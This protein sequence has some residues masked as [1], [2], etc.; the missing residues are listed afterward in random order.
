MKLKKML[1]LLDLSFC[2]IKGV[3]PSEICELK[4][5]AILRLA[6]NSFSGGL[7]IDFGNLDELIELDIRGNH[8]GEVQG[9]SEAPVMGVLSR[10]RSLEVLRAD[11]NMIRWT[12][13]WKDRIESRGKDIFPSY[14]NTEVTATNYL[15]NL[16]AFKSAP[17]E[18]LPKNDI[19]DEIDSEGQVGPARSLEFSK[20]RKLSLSLQGPGG[21]PKSAVLR[22]SNLTSSLI[23]LNISY[24]GLI[25]LPFRIFERLK[26]LEVLNVSGNRLKRLPPFTFPKVNSRSSPNNPSGLF[27]VTRTSGRVG[28]LQLKEL[29]ASNNELEGLPKEIGDL[30]QLA[31][32]EVNGNRIQEIPPEIWKCGAL[33][34]IN[35]CSNLL[36]IFPMPE[37][38]KETPFASKLRVPKPRTDQRTD[39]MP[40][41]PLST[42]FSPPSTSPLSA[43]TDSSAKT[44][45]GKRAE[46]SLLPLGNSLESL[47][48]AGNNLNDDIYLALHRLPHLTHVNLSLNGIVDITPLLSTLPQVNSNQNTWYNH[49][50][51]LFL[52]SNAIANIPG[53]IEKARSLRWLFLNGNR[54]NTVP[55][56]LAKLNKLKVLDLSGQLGGRGD[57]SGLRYNITNWPYDWN[58]NWNIEL[59]YLNLSGNTRL[60]IKPSPKSSNSSSDGGIPQK[61]LADFSALTKLRMLGLMD[62]TCLVVPPDETIDRRIRTTGSDM[63]M[64]G[65][66]SGH[67]GYGVAD[68]LGIAVDTPRELDPLTT[69]LNARA[70]SETS[71]TSPLSITS[72]ITLNSQ[73]SQTM[74]QDVNIGVWDLVQP[75]FRGRDNEALFGVFDGRGSRYGNRFAKYLYDNLGIFFAKELNVIESELA[76]STS[77][78]HIMDA[79]ATPILDSNLIKDALRRAF[80][81]ANRE[82]GNYFQSLVDNHHED[83]EVSVG[84]GTSFSSG[85]SRR[86]G[87]NGS[88]DISSSVDPQWLCGCSATVVFMLGPL[89]DEGASRCSVYSANVGDGLSAISRAGG[90]AHIL[91][92]YHSLATDSFSNRKMLQP[93]KAAHKDLKQNASSICIN[94]LRENGES[95]S[96]LNLAE[97]EGMS[98][99]D[100]DG[101]ETYSQWPESEV[102]RIRAAGGWI[103]NSGLVNGNIEVTRSFGY[104]NLLGAV[105]AEP[106]ISHEELDLGD[107]S[108]DWENSKDTDDAR[109]GPAPKKGDEFLVLASYGIWKSLSLGGTYEDG[110]STIV[111]VARTAAIASRPQAA[112]IPLSTSN[113]SGKNGWNASKGTPSKH[114]AI[115]TGWSSAA[116]MVRD[117][118]IGYNGGNF[119]N[120]Y[121][122]MI[123]GL[124]D[125]AS[126]MKRGDALSSQ[127]DVAQS[128]TQMKWYPDTNIIFSNKSKHSLYKDIQ[129]PTGRIALVFTDIKNSTALWE[130]YPNAMRNAIKLHN[131]IMRKLLLSCGGYEV[132]TEGDAFMVSFQDIVG[133]VEWCMRAQL[134]LRT[135]DWPKEILGCPDGAEISWWRN[136][137]NEHIEEYTGSPHESK[138]TLFRGLWVRMGIHFGSP[139]CEVDPVTGRM[140]YYGPVVNRSARV[141]SVSQG[142]Q[143]LVSYDAMKEI[144][145]RIGYRTSLT[146][147]NL[148]P[149]LATMS[150][151]WRIID[152][153]NIMDSSSK[154]ALDEK[155]QSI[156]AMGLHAWYVGE[157]KLKGLEAPEVLYMIYPTELK[158]RQKY[159][160]QAQN[161]TSPITTQRKPS[162]YSAPS[163]PAVSI[164]KTMLEE[165]ANV[166][167][168]LEALAAK[169]GDDWHSKKNSGDFSL[170]AAH[171]NNHIASHSSHHPVLTINT[172]STYQARPS[173]TLL[174]PASA[175]TIQKFGASNASMTPQSPVST[176]SANRRSF[177]PSSHW[178]KAGKGQTPPEQTN[179]E[180]PEP[181]SPIAI[182]SDL[183]T[184]IEIAV[185]ILYMTRSSPFSKVLRSLG[186]AM[187]DDPN[188]VIQALQMYTQSLSDRKKLQR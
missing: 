144:Q 113:S 32:V 57:G 56:E 93:V 68:V 126:R 28:A 78:S 175:L 106:Y 140:D 162:V 77:H 19:T 117:K 132:K 176:G 131:S 60:E 22:L 44:L 127:I 156:K 80:L 115:G 53:E 173:N 8:F 24:S 50:S 122:I 62:V 96:L 17:P 116:T 23:H 37:E 149:V 38:V 43:T 26:G 168:R 186:E 100:E 92:R 160:T 158:L 141:S 49:L 75:K 121:A 45:V 118:A 179:T 69:Q 163:D 87:A 98:S 110:A 120:G 185:S 135:I 65:V 84:R 101:A 64:I 59:R 95:S 4:N 174:S 145:T 11:C 70:L 108:S 143:I 66:P 74:D 14:C 161:G 137:H 188:Q 34:T 27:A 76:L 3:L 42:Q 155:V 71:I 72:G 88:F 18:D 30:C 40:G 125:L 109:A 136:N 91:S 2:G 55:G 35:A 138:V 139:L 165:L 21:V 124:K 46:E 154:V 111:N 6:F 25:D 54:L 130:N 153:E 61:D 134:E 7:P 33:K 159:L 29:Y 52:S 102:E 164:D 180:K 172:S 51:T 129:P 112:K 63:P 83:I 82:L 150:L 104:Y 133:A 13:R 148:S 86:T 99:L 5:L 1:R 89:S 152:G 10:C 48:L 20:L 151:C 85:N 31:I 16:E 146:P 9:C 142:G 114:T 79:Q 157:V 105:I 12:G 147:Q 166:C 73:S 39:T 128:Q 107:T 81:H 97:R 123:L 41:S 47:N 169:S 177:L 90:K 15:K 170:S 167:Q 178:L 182:L 58:W 184:R 103:S 187:D 119:G 67:I 36:E 171:L 94:L 183:S 181:E